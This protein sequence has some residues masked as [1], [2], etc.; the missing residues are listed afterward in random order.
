MLQEIASG[1]VI[2]VAY[3][4]ESYMQ[5]Y[6]HI[7]PASLS[8]TGGADNKM[9]P[10]G[11]CK[12]SDMPKGVVIVAHVFVQCYDPFSRHK[13]SYCHSCNPLPCIPLAPKTVYPGLCDL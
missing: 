1:V 9:N 13:L 7:V 10:P 2:G 11:N 4:W 8:P 5:R 6:D 12:A 3:E